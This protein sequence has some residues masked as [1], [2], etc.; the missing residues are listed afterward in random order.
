[1]PAAASFLFARRCRSQF[2]LFFSSLSVR[3]SAGRAFP[4]THI[5]PSSSPSRH[6]LPRH[7]ITSPA[8]MPRRRGFRIGVNGIFT[9]WPVGCRLLAAVTVRLTVISGHPRV[10]RARAV[11]AV[12]VAYG[13]CM[14]EGHKEGHVNGAGS[15]A[16]HSTASLPVQVKSCHCRY[17]QMEG[18]CC[19][20]EGGG[21]AGSGSTPTTDRP[22]HWRG[23]G[24]EERLPAAQLFCLREA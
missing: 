14:E 5:M 24:E 13:T 17:H 16:S 20:C 22:H 9:L 15:H 23:E 21:E 3:F 4:V 11:C 10:K 7:V 19:A 8:S 6:A 18:G 12:C 1:M 2:C